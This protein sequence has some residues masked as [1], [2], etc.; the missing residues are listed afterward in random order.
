MTRTP[1]TP[2][3]LEIELVDS[4]TQLEVPISQHLKQRITRPLPAVSLMPEPK[5][6]SNLS[7]SNWLWP[8]III[9]SAVAAGLV[10]FVFT[11]TIVRPALVFWFLFVCPGMMVVRFLHLKELV[12]EWTIALALS[13]AID[14]LV[15]GIQLYAGKWSPTGTL[16]ILIGLSLGGAIVQLV[17]STLS[18]PNLLHT[19]RSR[20]VQTLLHT[21]RS[22]KPGV[23]L[24]ILLT[25]LVGIV[26]GASLWSD[27][28][29]HSSH[30]VT[31]A[32]AQLHGTTTHSSSMVV[33]APTRSSTPSAIRA[34]SYHGTIFNIAANLTTKMSLTGIEPGS[35]SGYFT[36]LSLK[37]PFK[38][39]IDGSKL[40]QLIVTDS[41]GRAILSFDGNV[42]SD[43]NIGGNYCSLNQA[44]RCGG[45]YGYGLWSVAPAS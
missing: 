33:S 27:E 26:V 2:S 30:S 37:G 29:Y 12:V 36:G 22:R 8:T 39:F 34:G 6:T 20:S 1:S 43:G 44:E 18:V 19:V 41:A 9:F 11:D 40:I 28:V 42:Q 35:I 21:V 16:S 7:E 32:S 3:P 24:P 31:T 10:Y 45:S 17:T 25:L 5:A 38:G 4:Q 14:A 23:L 13:F 15:A